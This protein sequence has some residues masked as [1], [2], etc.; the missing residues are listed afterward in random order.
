MEHRLS[1]RIL[2]KLPILVYKRGLPVA[3][4]QIINASRRGAFIATDY[5]DVAL[6][7]SI[8]LELCYPGRAGRLKAHIVRKAADGLGVDFD[9]TEQD[10]LDISRLLQWLQ[11][12][13]AAASFHPPFRRR[14]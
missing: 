1:T 4:G 12:Q 14:A 8:E 9:T 10:A 13:S 11:D 3:S 2:G 6:N 5:D 7:Q